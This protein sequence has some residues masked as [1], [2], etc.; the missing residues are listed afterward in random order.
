MALGTITQVQ[1]DPH[2]QQG[3]VPTSVG[4]VKCTVTNIVGDSS[5]PTGG[6]AVT[7]QQLGLPVTVLFTQ[8]EA[9]ATTGANNGASSFYYNTS[10]GKLQCFTTGATGAFNEV[11]NAVNL[12]GLTIQILAFGY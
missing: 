2:T 12:S 1:V 5:Y 4:D 3:G 6:T 8:S 11:A 9:I 10:T 7:P